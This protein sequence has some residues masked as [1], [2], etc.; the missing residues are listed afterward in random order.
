MPLKLP[1][2]SQL[3]TF[4]EAIAEVIRVF[5]IQPLTLQDVLSA[6]VSPYPINPQL[7]INGDIVKVTQYFA[8]QGWIQI[9]RFDPEQWQFRYLDVIPLPNIAFEITDKFPSSGETVTLQIPARTVHAPRDLAAEAIR[10]TSAYRA[11]YVLENRL[12]QFIEA[13]LSAQFGVEWLDSGVDSKIASEIRR[14]AQHER[15]NWES[16]VVYPQLAY[17][18][19]GHLADIVR[20]NEDSKLLFRSLQVSRDFEGRIRKL[21]NLRDHLA[22]MRPFAA[23][24][25]EEFF[26]ECDALLRMLDEKEGS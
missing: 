26:R 10:M 13:G 21:D 2:E 22:H 18:D 11:F 4:R 7:I 5:G 19:F 12:R 17:A 23:S 16:D 24:A 6:H 20:H 25:Q 1:L 3:G 14:Y 15:T 8:D 9:T